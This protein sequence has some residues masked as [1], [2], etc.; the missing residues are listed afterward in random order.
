MID[1]KSK[2]AVWNYF[3]ISETETEIETETETEIETSLKLL[4]LVQGAIL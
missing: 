3:P 2:D 1:K 4:K